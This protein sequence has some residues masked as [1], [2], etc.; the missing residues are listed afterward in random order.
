MRYQAVFAIL[1]ATLV[2]QCTAGCWYSIGG[3]SFNR[4][5]I[6]GTKTGTCCKELGGIF[7]VFGTSG[8]FHINKSNFTT[9]CE[10]GGGV[11]SCNNA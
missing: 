9:C 10:R 5:S 2:S 4:Y 7:W 1:L 11:G 8:C 6:N 3:N